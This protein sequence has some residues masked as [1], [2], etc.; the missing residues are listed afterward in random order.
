MVNLTIIGLGQIG[1]SVGLALAE[2]K[3]LLRRVG[4][5]KEVKIAR[6]AEKIGAIDR[7]EMNLHKA[8]INADLVLISL[9]IDQ[10]KKTIELIAD[11]LKENAV[12]MDTGPVKQA[13]VAW[14]GEFLP[15]NRHYVGLTPVINP[16]YLHEVDTGIDAAQSDLFQGGLFAIVSS[17]IVSPDAVKLAADLARLVG[18]FPLFADPVEIDGLMAATHVLPQ[19]VAAALLNATIDQPG[20]QDGRKVAGRAYAEVSAPIVHLGDAQSLSASAALNGENVIRV[21]DSTI[22]ALHAIRN[23]IENQDEHALKDRLS[24]A[25][26]GREKWWYDRQSGEWAGDGLPSVEAPETPGALGRLFGFGRK[27]RKDRKAGE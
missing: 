18:A 24:R 5:D 12:L 14:A 27:S 8:V 15:P 11:D 10:M 6:Q 9:P 7:V 21:L 20:W 4:H 22:A 26:I 16:A 23:D 19:L 1:A 17:R 13:V 3:E 25:R 2:R